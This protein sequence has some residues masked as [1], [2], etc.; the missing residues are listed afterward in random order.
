MRGVGLRLWGTIGLA[1]SV[2]AGCH[3]TSPNQTLRPPKHPEEYTVPPEE[4][5]R[6]SQPPEYPKD[7]LN[8][9][10]LIQPKNSGPGLPGPNG[11]TPGTMTNPSRSNP[12]STYGARPY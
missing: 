5:L 4:D 6:F 8:K 11:A 1:L 3:W 9:D 12:N 2:L 10:N 7:V